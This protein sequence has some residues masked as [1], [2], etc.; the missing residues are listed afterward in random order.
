MRASVNRHTPSRLEIGVS[1]HF[2]IGIGALRARTGGLAAMI[3][4]RK[5]GWG[6]H[7]LL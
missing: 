7:L 4:Y 2:S 1:D 3:V 6:F 5:T